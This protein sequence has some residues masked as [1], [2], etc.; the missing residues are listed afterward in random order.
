MP[1]LMESQLTA[2][3]MI[4]NF[5]VNRYGEFALLK[6]SSSGFNLVLW[7]S[8]PFMLFL[9]IIISISFIRSNQRFGRNNHSSLS[10][11]EKKELEKIINDQ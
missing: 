10:E 11:V 1:Q 2:I 3:L 8:G 5:V 6:P 7:L 4:L 9:A